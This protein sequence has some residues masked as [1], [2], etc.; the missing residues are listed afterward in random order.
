MPCRSPL[1]IPLRARG[2][3]FG[4]IVKSTFTYLLPSLVYRLLIVL[5]SI[6]SSCSCHA[7]LVAICVLPA[8]LLSPFLRTCMHLPSS[9]TPTL[10]SIHSPAHPLAIVRRPDP[11][12]SNSPAFL[13]QLPLRHS[14]STRRL[15]AALI[16]VN[17]PSGPFILAVATAAVACWPDAAPRRSREHE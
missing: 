5:A 4:R 6:S 17:W 15:S 11:E 1:G 16:I 3:G 10:H 14:Q 12:G 9:F 7:N 2:E 13:R 8:S